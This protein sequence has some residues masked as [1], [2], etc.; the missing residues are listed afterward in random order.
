MGSGGD[1]APFSQE[2]FARASETCGRQHPPSKLDSELPRTW[3]DHRETFSVAHVAE[4]D[5]PVPFRPGLLAELPRT[6]LQEGRAHLLKTGVST[7]L[8]LRLW[9]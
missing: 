8:Q 7:E 3:P 1:G 6:L 2:S 9:G 4:T 5:V